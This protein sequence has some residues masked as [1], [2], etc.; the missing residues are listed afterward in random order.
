VSRSSLCEALTRKCW[1]LRLART[2]E[3]KPE[4]TQKWNRF[5]IFLRENTESRGV[6]QKIGRLG[7]M[8]TS[9]PHLRPRATRL[10]PRRLMQSLILWGGWRQARAAFGAKQGVRRRKRNLPVTQFNASCKHLGSTNQ[11]LHSNDVRT[12]WSNYMIP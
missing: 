7:C 12:T 4:D 5:N 9:L 1:G 11:Y 8:V 6:S 10:C 2:R 3:I